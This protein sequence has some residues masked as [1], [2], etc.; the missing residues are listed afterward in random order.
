M[1]PTING[2]SLL[3][4][5]EEE[6]QAIL[7]NADYRESE[8]LDYKKNFAFLEV[9]KNDSRRNEL[10]AE[11]RS[12]VCSFANTNGGYLIYGVKEVKGIPVEFVGIGIPDDNTDKFELARKENL[13]LISPRLPSFKFSFIKLNN[14]KYIVILYIQNDFYAPYICLENQKDY[15][16]YKRVLSSKTPMNYTEVKNMFLQSL[17]L[18]KEMH[19][20][21]T[22][23]IQYYKGLCEDEQDARYSKYLLLHIIPD[24]FADRSKDKNMYMLLRNQSIAFRSMFGDFSC[25]TFEK[26]CV[27]GLRC[28]SYSGNEECKVYNNGIVEVFQ[29][30]N[31][32]TDNVSPAKGGYTVRLATIDLWRRIENTINNYIST[33]A[34]VIDTTRIFVCTSIIGGKGIIT[35]VGNFSSEISIIDRNLLLLPPAA[36]EDMANDDSNAKAI[37]MHHLEYRLALGLMGKETQELIAEV[38]K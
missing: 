10:L 4:C 22:D 18:E 25:S 14:G 37:N 16:I 23:R 8:C 32:F 19:N 35:G 26:P 7:N 12:D 21:R 13:S 1:L 38:S 6:L 9:E 24:T 3:D 28:Q 2:K 20:Y 33:M 29:P 27:D 5:N 36:F 31:E 34:N 30:L 17:S 11:F 15:H